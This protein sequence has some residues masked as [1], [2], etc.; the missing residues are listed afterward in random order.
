SA[1]A[2]GG[3]SAGNYYFALKHRNHLG[4]MTQTPISLGNTSLTVNFADGTSPTYGSNAQNPIGNTG[5]YCMVS[6]NANSDKVVDAA[7]RSTLWNF[8]S[9]IGYLLYDVTCDGVNDAADRSAGWNNRN[10]VEQIPD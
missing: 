1:V 5:H 8:R 10:R 9:T 2:F 7:D 4:V 6:A 3:V